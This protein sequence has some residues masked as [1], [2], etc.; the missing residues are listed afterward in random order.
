MFVNLF[1]CVCYREEYF[2]GESEKQE[3]EDELE[4]SLLQELPSVTPTSEQENQNPAPLVSTQL[5]E[6]VSQVQN[7]SK[8]VMTQTHEINNSTRPSVPKHG[9]KYG[10]HQTFSRKDEEQQYQEELGLIKGAKVRCSLHLLVQQ[11]RGGCQYPG[12]IHDT[13]LDY[14]LCGTSAM[15]RCKCPAGHMQRFCTSGEVNNILP[16]NFQAAAAVLLSGNNFSKIEKFSEFMGL[17]FISPST[18]FRVPKLYCI[19]TIEGWWQ[20]MRGQ[21]VVEFK[22]K[23]GVVMTSAIRLDFQLRIFATTSWKL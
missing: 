21:L 14:T 19:A 18:F 7:S 13:K 20:C 8:S 16:K 22:N 9:S 11:L 6:T 5:E 3:G 10:P 4:A 17:S 1:S 12:C 2:E 15:I 23:K